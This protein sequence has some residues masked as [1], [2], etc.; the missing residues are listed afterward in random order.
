MKFFCKINK[1]KYFITFFFLFQHWNQLSRFQ[2]NII[3]TIIFAIF[4]TL[5]LLIPSGDSSIVSDL[6]KDE[7]NHIR[8]APF[9]YE[10]RKMDKIEKL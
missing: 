1:F 7:G 6:K 2:R 9:K 3:L 5:L 10:V 4:V 8:I